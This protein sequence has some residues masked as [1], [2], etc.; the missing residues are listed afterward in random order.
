MSTVKGPGKE[1]QC[2]HDWFK[3][4]HHKT[5]VIEFYWHTWTCEESLKYK[6]QKLDTQNC[7]CNGGIQQL[8]CFCSIKKV[9]LYPGTVWI[10]HPFNFLHNFSTKII[11]S[12]PYS[13]IDSIDYINWN[14]YQINQYW[15]KPWRNN[16]IKSLS[17][18]YKSSDPEAWH[19]QLRGEFSFSP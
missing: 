10:V 19:K 12:N 8:M 11:C 15:I 2:S 17:G 13:I 14:C 16:V 18:S 6:M 7:N 4:C 9:K 5:S 3:Q 1:R